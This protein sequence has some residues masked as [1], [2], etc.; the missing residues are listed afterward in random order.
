MQPGPILFV[1]SVTMLAMG[2]LMLIPA[3]VGAFSRFEDSQPFLDAA[4]VVLVPAL[5]VFAVARRPNVQVV[6]R[7]AFFITTLVWTI[8][9][10]A[11]ALPLGLHEHLRITDAFFES[12]SG[13]TTTGSTVLVGLDNL[14][15]A[16]LLW[17]SM[18]QWIGGLGFML[19]AIAILPM[20]G[21][22]GMRLFR[23]ES[24]DWSEKSLPRTRDLAS[25]IALLYLVLTGLCA[26]GYWLF[27]MPG[28]DAVNHAMTTLATGGYSTSDLSMGKYDSAPILWTSTLF[29]LL[30][31][32]PFVLYIRALR[33]GPGTVLHDD[34]V[35]FFLK[36]VLVVVLAG[37]AVLAS[38]GDYSTL[39][40]LTAVAFNVVSTISTTGFAST[41][42]TLWGEFF[43]G[44]F[45][46]LMF[47]GGCSGSTA[48]S[49]KA[50]RIQIAFTLLNL[51][52][53]KLVHP[54]GVFVA[55]LNGNRIDP[56]ITAALVAFIFAVGLTV[57]GVS[58]VLTLLGIDFLTALSAAATAVT[59]VGP[60]VGP[61][62]GPAGNF[63]TLPD[64]AK[65]LL[66]VAMLL[67]RLELMTVVVLLSRS[68]WEG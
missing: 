65:W 16:I 20:V 68:Y 45:L 57:I 63:S 38:Q 49:I 60:G 24:S 18:L 17:R 30:A 54:N 32:I 67:G 3:L 36:M 10:L 2:D 26:A 28:F 39:E 21:V 66:A 6:P 41:D 61:I 37:T 48:G 25:Q 15:P 4:A 59:N 34:Q 40:A 64:L 46:F 22:G 29:M 33:G 5:V 12:M 58:I 9:G 7:Q 44:G 19:M 14:S 35:K 55:K 47:T 8:A 23:S 51:Q 11:G 27:G 56:E 50:F 43:V 1:V 42:Y 13:I 52:V 53:K 31:S 62:V